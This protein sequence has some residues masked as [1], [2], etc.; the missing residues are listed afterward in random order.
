VQLSRVS[1][2]FRKTFLPR[3]AWLGCG[4]ASLC[5]GWVAWG[6]LLV[7]WG[8]GDATPQPTHRTSYALSAERLRTRACPSLGPFSET[9]FGSGPFSEMRSPSL[10][11]MHPIGMQGMHGTP[12]PSDETGLG[13]HCFAMRASGQRNGLGVALQGNAEGGGG[14]ALLVASLCDARAEPPMQCNLRPLPP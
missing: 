3:S 10:H 6:A 14:R 12:N 2:P 13:F 4:V 5:S 11:P 8:L 9:G 1:N 7:R